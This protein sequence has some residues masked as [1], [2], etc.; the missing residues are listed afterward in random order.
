M[1]TDDAEAA[2]YCPPHCGFVV[3][4]VNH[5]KAE[6]PNDRLEQKQHCLITVSSI[7]VYVARDHLMSFDFGQASESD[8]RVAVFMPRFSV[9][10]S[11]VR[12]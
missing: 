12:V 8:Q 3:G 7:S 2:F 6:K 10:N 1:M 4:N 11:H 9:W 5:A